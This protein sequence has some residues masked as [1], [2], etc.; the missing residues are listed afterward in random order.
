MPPM[1]PAMMMNI[2]MK[3]RICAARCCEVET[4]NLLDCRAVARRLG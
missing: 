3:F 1:K 2:G 4:S